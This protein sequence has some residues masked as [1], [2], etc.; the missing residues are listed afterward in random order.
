MPASERGGGAFGVLNALDQHV[1]AVTTP[2]QFAV[3]H[4]GGYVEHAEF[5]RFIDEGLTVILLSNL[6]SSPLY[7][8][9][10]EIAEI[11]LDE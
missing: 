4:H 11:Y 9:A 10:G 5:F 2:E 6:S 3:E 8:M 7:G 1:D